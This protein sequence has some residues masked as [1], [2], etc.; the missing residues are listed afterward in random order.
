M[1]IVATRKYALDM[2][3][4]PFDQIQRHGVDVFFGQWHFNVGIGLRGADLPWRVG[5]S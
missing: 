2:S 1:K 5:Q 3:V 4:G